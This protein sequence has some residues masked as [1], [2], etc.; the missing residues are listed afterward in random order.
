[1]PALLLAAAIGAVYLA[2]APATTDL[3]A[4]TYRADLF[5]RAGFL[6]WDN[7]WYGGHHLPGYSVLFPPLGN[8]FGVRLV[9]V[10][11]LLAATAGFHRLIRRHTHGEA[12]AVWFAL[13]LGAATI[14]GRIP[15]VLG[16]AFAIWAAV[17]AT[18]AR[19][20]PA[21]ALGIATAASSP[22]AALF[23]ALA[24]AAS[25]LG[26][27]TR[28][29]A[30]ATSP[31]ARRD[32][33]VR[34]AWL[35][36]GATAAATTAAMVLM[37]PEGGSEPF[38]PSSFWPALAAT[39]LAFA[40]APRGPLRT[41]AALYA[42]VLIAAFAIPSPLGGNAARLGALLV[43]PLA[44]LVLLPARRGLLVAALLPLAWWTLYPATRDW[45]DAAGDPSTKAAY[46]APLLTELA[47]RAGPADRV[48]I[49][50]TARHWEASYV[51]DRIPIAR[52][53]ERQLDRKVN[54][55]FYEGTLTAERYRRWLL[56]AA[57]RFVALPDAALD[58]S[59]EAEA[60]IV[61]S[62]PQ[63]LREVRR[64]AHWRLFEVRG[65]R[66]TGATRISPGGFTT[67]GDRVVR[68]RFT[69]YWA[70][71][72]GSGCVERAPGGW[73]RVRSRSATE[74][75]LR[76]GVGRVFGHGARCSS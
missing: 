47:G 73:T 16:T 66:A 20:A 40:L 35:T 55:V 8:W 17:A 26:G 51:A 69:P 37:F 10:I 2:A 25:W 38:V 14:S 61:R 43:G 67:T 32:H 59:A 5:D 28:R 27:G 1:M 68:V 7:S 18:T 70:V 41:G 50:L 33:R 30:S 29:G 49:P 60:R 19:R 15:F 24:A 75:G 23:L 4:Q 72:R 34:A 22:V 63:Y 53:W 11:A 58:A 57:V 64:T 9:G 56:D 48:E 74:I 44:L 62:Q 71:V 21:A 52:G 39:A 76:F 42:L 54:A 12:A 3:A 36:A 65:A 31:V 6:L 46:Y 13:A 45:I